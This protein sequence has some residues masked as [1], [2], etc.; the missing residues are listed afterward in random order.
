MKV[1]DFI[2]QETQIH[3]LMNSSEDVTVNAT[4]MSKAFPN[5]RMNDFISNKQTQD[6]VSLLESKTGIPVLL[7]NHG[8]ANPGTWMNRKL[9]LKFAAW[10]DPEFELW[11]I[12]TIESLMF[13]NYD[14]HLKALSLQQQ[15]IIY[16]DSLI[17]KATYEQNELALQIIESYRRLERFKKDKKNALSRQT[18][19]VRNLFTPEEGE[20]NM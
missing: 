20:E 12:E 18:T 13:S 19:H 7:V 3:F 17:R 14:N 9:A 8:G 2:Y 1:R 16:H 5:K 10:L 4:E 15:E 6:F 11:I